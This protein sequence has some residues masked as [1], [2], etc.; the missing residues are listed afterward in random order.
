MNPKS[1]AVLGGGNTAFSIAANLTLRGYEIT[2]YEIPGFENNIEVLRQTKEI[3]LAGV[4]EAG[5]A[6]IHKVTTDIQEALE[7]KELI[8]ISVP[9]YAHKPFAQVCAPHLDRGQV[10][11]LLPGTL[12][13]LEFSKILRD[14][15]KGEG[16]ILGE[17]DTSPYVCRK[18]AP[19]EAH[20][21]GIVT[22]LGLG[23]LPSAKTE[24][25][26]E[27]LKDVFPGIAPHSSAL[28][29]GLGS[30][31][32]VV[33]PAGVLMNAGRIEYSKGEFYFY[34]EGISPAVADVIKKV[35]D[36]RRAIGLAVGIDLSSVEEGFHRA[37]F[38]PKGTIWEVIN[39]SRMLTQLR[40]P[41]SLQNRWLT[42]D[43]PYGL[44]TWISIAE[45][46]GV[47]TPVMR[48][49][50]EIASIVVHEDCWKS[51][52]TVEDLGIRGMAKEELS[53]FLKDGRI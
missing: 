26:A 37:G 43:V 19:N 13:T 45:Q 48:S 20:I 6:R 52:R 1:I 28:E 35:D 25:V 2:L 15:G 5:T 21:W 50:V 11:V 42:E 29:C 44:V 46:F 16:M 41:V 9:A 4:A 23:V 47:S 38:G 36:E 18:V 24:Y 3:H 10:V 39:G 17:T 32:P 40:A 12:G 22:G 30:M 34:E 53:L 8:F 7:G 51:G 14:S 31:N 33:H 27:M 49:L